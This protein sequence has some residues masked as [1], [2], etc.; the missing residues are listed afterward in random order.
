M[1]ES[2][3]ID[4]LDYAPLV[5]AK[6]KEEIASGFI[7]PSPSGSSCQFCKFGGM[8]GFCKD[9]SEHRKEDSI[10]PKN[11]ANI[12]R[13]VKGISAPVQPTKGATTSVKNKKGGN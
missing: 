13:N 10:D 8:C 2:D 12:V 7:A 6:G 4:F 9:V 5:A 11:I 3:F 1:E